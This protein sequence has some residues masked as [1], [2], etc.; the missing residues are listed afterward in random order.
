MPPVHAAAAI[1]ETGSDK[2]EEQVGLILLGVRW[3]VPAPL[4]DGRL[5]DLL[6]MCARYGVC[7]T[8]GER[9]LDPN[10][11][12]PSVELALTRAITQRSLSAAGVDDALKL[13]SVAQF[14]LGEFCRQITG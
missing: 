6:D 3:R 2:L 12:S 9:H 11:P 1:L 7:L 13:L 14:E 10:R 4:V 8:V 5:L